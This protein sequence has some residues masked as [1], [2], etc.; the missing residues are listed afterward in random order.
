L[1]Q[2]LLGQFT[3]TDRLFQLTTTLGEDAL[4]VESVRGLESVFD[5]PLP[6]GAQGLLPDARQFPPGSWVEQQHAVPQPMLGN[7]PIW[8]SL[9]GPAPQ[10]AMAL[11]TGYRLLVT[12]VAP[13]AHD[14]LHALLGTPA[15]LAMQ[16][17]LSRNTRR[18]FHGHITEVCSQGSN[19]GL[20]R[21]QLV[22]EPWLSFLRL[23]R[24]SWVFQEQTVP[25]ILDTLFRD[26]QGK[27]Q[28]VPDWRFKLLDRGIYPQRSLITQYQE[29][30][31]HFVARLMQAE[32]LFGWFEHQ[33]DRH[34]LVIS[35]RMS[36]DSACQAN[37]ESPI[38]YHRGAATETRDTFQHWQE[39]VT[40]QPGQ[41]RLASYDYRTLSPNTVEAASL[42]P[43]CRRSPGTTQH[44]DHVSHYAWVNQA[45]GQRRADNLQAGFDVLARHCQA[46]GTVRTLAPAQTFQ[47]NQYPRYGDGARVRVLSVLHEGRN[48]LQ[49]DLQALLH[50]AFAQ[51]GSPAQPQVEFYR[52]QSLC[53]EA[54]VDQG[55]RHYD[56]PYS[57]PLPRHFDKPTASGSQTATVVGQ[58]GRPLDT[59]RNHRV[60]LQFHWQRGQRS[61]NR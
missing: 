21:Y 45:D 20:A 28:L 22:I 33:D 54:G 14:N 1:F 10:P 3:A 18:P 13:T 61:H 19:G 11:F 2:Q 39:Q 56:L 59:D 46:T 43:H 30:D 47:L 8:P 50:Q 52:N 32:G 60:K 53:L 29:S 15:L 24:D 26:Y 23:N 44:V 6:I 25:D 31:W 42:L 49:A 58:A 55:D 34:T 12:V 37:P 7:I 35:D 36:F 40:R 51:P 4:L 9:Q 57:P 41:V 5:A 27:G 38:R 17:G 48:N 16:T